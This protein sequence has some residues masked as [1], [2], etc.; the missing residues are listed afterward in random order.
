MDSVEIKEFGDVLHIKLTHNEQE[1][2][3]KFM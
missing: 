2:F 3:Y 1:K